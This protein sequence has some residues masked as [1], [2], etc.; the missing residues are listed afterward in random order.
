MHGWGIVHFISLSLG[1]LFCKMGEELKMRSLGT[2]E[3]WV[4]PDQKLQETDLSPSTRDD[5]GCPIR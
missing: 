4:S 3:G 1:F 5:V 2:A